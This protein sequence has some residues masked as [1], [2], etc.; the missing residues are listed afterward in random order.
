MPDQQAA[1]RV[2]A[3]VFDGFELLDLFGP[4]ELLGQL[5]DHFDLR[6]VGPSLDPV[7]SGQG[8]RCTPDRTLEDVGGCDILLVP[9]GPGTRDLVHDRTFLNRL[10]ALGESAS[11]VTSVCTGSAL[12]AAAGLLDG[13]RAT[14]NKA[15]FGWATSQGPHVQWV[16]TARWVHDRDRWTSS[17]VAAGMD[18]TL[19]LIAELQGSDTAQRIADMT[20]LEWHT[21]ANWDPF[22]ALHGLSGTS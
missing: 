5:P 18:M 4:L 22:A 9:G 1:A 6:L 17:G 16:S 19:A 15:A 2:A 11:L 12:L 3:V 10:K 21:D 8:P 13:Y 20:E 14:S 7:R